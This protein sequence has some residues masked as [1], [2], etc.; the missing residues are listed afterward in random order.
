MSPLEL[1]MS[2][3]RLKCL[4]EFH[5]GGKKYEDEELWNEAKKQ[6]NDTDTELV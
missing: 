1:S 6:V 2:V 4:L 3:D 5:H